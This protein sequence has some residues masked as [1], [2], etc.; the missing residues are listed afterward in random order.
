MAEPEWMEKMRKE[1]RL[2]ETGVNVSALAS[3]ARVRTV[4]PTQAA[5]DGM[6]EKK[7]DECVVG[8]A[9]AN[10]WD[11]YHTYDSQKSVEGFPDRVFVRG[12]C[13]IFAELKKETGEATPAQLAWLEKLARTHN[14][15]Y[16]W[17]PSNWDEIVKRL[18]RRD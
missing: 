18:T 13:L 17:R 16:L 12:E 2:K 4:R 9:I 3:D 11:T 8:I 10:G 6:S 7:F 15:A 1:G 5:L 14:E